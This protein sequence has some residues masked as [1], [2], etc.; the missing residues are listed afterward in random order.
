M[1]PIQQ[2]IKIMRALR[3]PDSGCPWDLEQD[4]QSLIPFT[5]EEA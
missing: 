2:L 1:Q 5:I 4:F 3:D